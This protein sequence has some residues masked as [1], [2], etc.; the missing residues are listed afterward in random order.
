MQ[1]GTETEP[2]LIR[3]KGADRW[4]LGRI[5]RLH[6]GLLETQNK[7]KKWRQRLWWNRK[8]SVQYYLTTYFRILY[9]PVLYVP[10]ILNLSYEEKN[11]IDVINFLLQKSHKKKY[12]KILFY[13]VLIKM[14]TFVFFFVQL[15]HISTKF[16]LSINKNYHTKAIQ[17]KKSYE[18]FKKL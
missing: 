3:D 13:Y 14:T 4:G 2:F 18:T 12:F 9:H 15:P 10:W 1:R 7:H 5:D 11:A 17:K 16:Y 8:K 6:V